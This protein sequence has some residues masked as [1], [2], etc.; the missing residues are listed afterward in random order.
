MKKKTFWI[1]YIGNTEGK[2]MTKSLI[3]QTFEVY[4]KGDRYCT[5]DNKTSWAFHKYNVRMITS[6]SQDLPEELFEI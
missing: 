6:L 4:E 3:G 1:E 5:V 2:A